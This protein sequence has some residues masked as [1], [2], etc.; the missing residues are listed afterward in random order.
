M[1]AWQLRRP[2]GFTSLPQVH[3]EPRPGGNVHHTLP[4]WHHQQLFAWRL[5]AWETKGYLWYT[6]VYKPI[7]HFRC[8]ALGCDDYFASIGM[9]TEHPGSSIA[10]G[11]ILTVTVFYLGHEHLYKHS[12]DWRAFKVE[13]WSAVTLYKT[14][15]HF[16][17]YL[18]GIIRFT[19]PFGR[20]CMIKP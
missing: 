9:P 11:N 8:F 13:A 15:S 3:W 5:S 7:S 12:H 6:T 19:L 14:T 16:P 18:R 10:C 1:H 4:A 17:M 2:K 20:G